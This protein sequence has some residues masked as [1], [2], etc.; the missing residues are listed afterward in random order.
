[1]V[2][3]VAV[4]GTVEEVVA[5]LVAF[6]DAGA[7]HFIF[8]VATKLSDRNLMIDRILGDVMPAVREHVSANRI[9]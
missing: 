2:D 7:R 6:H 9:R 5:K 4:S 8:S 1:M 3:R